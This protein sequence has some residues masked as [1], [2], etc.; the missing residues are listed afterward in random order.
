MNKKGYVRHVRQDRDTEAGSSPVE[1]ETR[2]VFQIG[3]T[4]IIATAYYQDEGKSC[5]DRLVNMLIE[6]VEKQ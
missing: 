6:E 2:A 1:L 4:A 3:D 5:A